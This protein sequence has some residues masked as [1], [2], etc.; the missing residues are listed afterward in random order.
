MPS[1]EPVTNQSNPSEEES[2]L[3]QT[4]KSEIK[5]KQQAQIA[6]NTLK[7]NAVK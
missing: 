5:L 2:W 6:T 7:K 4:I 1:M 3:Q